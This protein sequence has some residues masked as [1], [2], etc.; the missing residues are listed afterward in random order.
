MRDSTLRPSGDSCKPVGRRGYRYAGV[1]LAL[2][3]ATALVNCWH[4][5][6]TAPTERQQLWAWAEYRSLSERARAVGDDP[7]VRG[8]LERFVAETEERYGLTAADLSRLG[9]THGERWL[10]SDACRAPAEPIRMHALVVAPRAVRPLRGAYTPAACARG[11]EGVAIL[12]L[13]LNPEGRAE[14]VR[15]SFTASALRL[16][17]SGRGRGPVGPLAPGASSAPA[18]SQCRAGPSRCLSASGDGL[19]TRTPPPEHRRPWFHLTLLPRP[20]AL[21]PPSCPR[22]S[23]ARAP[24]LD[25]A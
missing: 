7:A 24:H 14:V 5:E 18:V 13:R 21:L 1:F 22:R 6:R 4:N 12:E 3:A 25:S 16:T 8:E 15:A 10:A 11:T 19:S 9:A 23:G 17:E 2:L 20:S